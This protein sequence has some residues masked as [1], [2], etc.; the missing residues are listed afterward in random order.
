MTSPASR[1]FTQPFIQAQI[2]KTS[3]LRVT[4]LYAGNSSVTGEFPALRASNAENVSICWRHHVLSQPIS[5]LAISSPSASTKE[6]RSKCN[7][8][9]N[10]RGSGPLYI[11]KPN[12]LSSWLQFMVMTR[13]GTR[14]LAHTSPNINTYSYSYEPPIRSSCRLLMQMFIHVDLWHP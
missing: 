8:R 10:T 1:S 2:K 13:T 9:E 12:S 11:G 5:R 3:K 4:C 6:K 14:F 7:K